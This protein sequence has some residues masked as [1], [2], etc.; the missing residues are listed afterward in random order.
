L[1]LSSEQREVIAQFDHKWREMFREVVRMAPDERERREV[2]LAQEQETQIAQ[3]LTAA[4]MRRFK[5]IALQVRGPGAFLD[6]DVA[7]AL[8]LT[9]DQKRRIR[10]IEMEGRGRPGPGTSRKEFE[11]TRKATNERVQAVLSAEQL[12]GWR[13]MTGEPFE[14][15]WFPPRFPPPGAPGRK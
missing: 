5:Q 9:A 4:Q 7:T 12:K 6:E 13:E 11:A 3:L 1:K 15:T 14:R 8:R 2:N 10:A